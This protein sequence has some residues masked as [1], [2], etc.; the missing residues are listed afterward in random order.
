MEAP[1]SAAI[2]AS[3]RLPSSRSTTVSSRDGSL[4]SVNVTERA[5]HV[6][7]RSST[8]PGPWA[9]SDIAM[10]TRGRSSTWRYS[11]DYGVHNVVGASVQSE[12]LEHVR[13]EERRVGKAC[14][15]Q[16]W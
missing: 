14:R 3:V 11:H 13:S 10:L 4:L 7:E 6:P 12:R 5:F 16:V 8:T 15:V 9:T 2:S 1:V